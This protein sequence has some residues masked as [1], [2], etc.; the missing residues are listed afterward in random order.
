MHLVATS[1]LSLGLVPGGVRVIDSHRLC[2]LCRVRT[3]VLF[4]NGSRLVDNK[5]HHTRGAIFDRVGDEGKSNTH[6]SVDDVLLRSARCMSPLTSEDA[7]HIP[8]E[9]NM[10]ADLVRWK[11]LARVCDEWVDRAVK[12]I[13]G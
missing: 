3:K 8:V 7:E 4:E 11:I 6:L 10:L 9:R 5:S 1:A 13:V 2:K 12:L